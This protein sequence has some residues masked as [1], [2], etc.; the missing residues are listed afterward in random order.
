[1]EFS[2]R[3]Q[4]IKASPTLSV[5]SKAKALKAKGE[6]IINFAGGEPDFDTPEHIKEA[7]I[8]AIKE[9]YTKYTPSSGAPF[10]IDAIIDKFKTDNN[11]EYN[12]NQIVVSCGA[13]HSLFN[14]MQVL[15]DEGDEVIIP[16][17]YWVSYPE[18]VKFA[19]STPVVIKT[20]QTNNFKLKADILEKYITHKTKLLILNSPSNPTGTVYNRKELEEI[21]RVAVNRKI[22]VIS[23]EIY[24]K[25]IYDDNEH[26]SIASLGEDIYNLTITVNGVSK[27]YSM[28]GWRI[29]YLGANEEIAIKVK[30]LQS[31]STSNPTSISQKAAYCALTSDQNTVSEMVNEFDRRRKE[32]VKG[33]NSIRGFSTNEP[34]G[35]FYCFCNIKET[36]LTSMELSNKLLDEVRVAVIP[37]VAFGD[38][39][40]IRVSFA[41][42]FDEIE[43]GISRMKKLFG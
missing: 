10:L 15:C 39:N 13:K 9:G 11:L 3:A 12:K 16:S 19:E 14:L 23:D 31:H 27:A 7:A 8:K 4:F 36:G 2:K 1:M 33:L 25:I 43:E 21:A 38:D 35:S 6:N 37:G 32:I 5:T 34:Q 41:C 24:E 20:V 26:I 30:N 17:P 22:Y 18:I 28:T 42:S 40:F 29:G